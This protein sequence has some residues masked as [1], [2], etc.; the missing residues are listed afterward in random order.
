MLSDTFVPA[1]GNFISRVSLSM[2]ALSMMAIGLVPYFSLSQPNECIGRGV[3]LALST[4]GCICL[5]C[6][7]AVCESTNV[8]SCMGDEN[9]H[10]VTAV[11]FFLCYDVYMGVLA[12]RH[13]HASGRAGLLVC[14]L[15]S[16]ATK[17]R[18]V[19]AATLRALLQPGFGDETTGA[20]EQTL[21]LRAA[22]DDLA[23]PSFPWLACFE[24]AD[25]GSIAAFLLVYMH[26]VGTAFTFGVL[27]PQQGATPRPTVSVAPIKAPIKAASEPEP[28]ASISIQTLA[29]VLTGIATSTIAFTFALNLHQGNIHPETE[30]PMISDLWVHKPSNMISRYF[31]CLGGSLLAICHVCHY[32]AVAPSRAPA[33]SGALKFG[34]VSGVVS[35]FGLAVVGA[36]NEKELYPLHISSAIVFFAG[37]ALWAIADL[38]SSAHVWQGGSRAAAVVSL[39]ILVASKG[40]QLCHIIKRGDMHHGYHSPSTWA[41]LEWLAA[42]TLI[43]YFVLSNNSTPEM[44]TSVLAIYRAS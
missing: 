4:V 30:W 16:I 8:P 14:L 43:S 38:R 3:L 28:L 42:A 41:I 23:S 26:S 18:F 9:V 29:N 27:T 37:F 12:A 7:G 1:P 32:C 19:P 20:A 31:V 39:A 34:V 44:R 10:D 35:A 15:V 40:A 36:C 21:R 25:V 11:T 2:S 13:R 5:G 17:I 22:S 6:V 24:Y 33:H